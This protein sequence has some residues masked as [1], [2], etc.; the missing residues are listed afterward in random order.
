M[1]VDKTLDDD[2]GTTKCWIHTEKGRM[3]F[4]KVCDNAEFALFLMKVKYIGNLKT[5]GYSI[6]T[7]GLL[8]TRNRW[9][10]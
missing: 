9:V 10:I 6:E 8:K 1:K 7:T 5:D 2:K 3:L 4:D